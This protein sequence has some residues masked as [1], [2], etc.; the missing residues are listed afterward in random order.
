MMAG[1][2]PKKPGGEETGRGRKRRRL[3]LLQFRPGSSFLHRLDPRTKLAV[4]LVVSVAALIFSSLPALVLAFLF[5]L[6][7]AAISRLEMRLLRAM[8]LIVPLFIL[9]IVLDSLFSKVSG[10]PVYF[11]AQIGFLHPEVTAAGIIFA[12]AMGFRLL[13]IAAISFLFI[14]TTSPDDFVRGLRN[15]R[16]P[17]T[18]T[19]SLGFALRSMN[20]LANDTRQI[21][22]AQR[23]RGLELDRGNLIRNRN[24][25][26]ALFVPVTVSLLKRSKNTADAMQARGFVLSAPR[27]CYRP[28]KPGRPDL[29]MSVALAAFIII[30]FVTG[31]VFS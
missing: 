25:L 11:S 1:P 3:E 18:I 23:S 27:S 26:A 31:I 29:Y 19:F 12:V 30:L 24:K 21:V 7:L 13:A 2:N 16:V 5:V 28:L 14:M 20:V 6:A 9:V 15:M 17:A 10:G 22:D 8:T 4:L